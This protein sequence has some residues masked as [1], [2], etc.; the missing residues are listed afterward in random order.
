[1]DKVLYTTVLQRHGSF[2]QRVIER[3]RN[4]ILNFTKWQRDHWDKRWAS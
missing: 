4:L 1:M 2:V 3:L